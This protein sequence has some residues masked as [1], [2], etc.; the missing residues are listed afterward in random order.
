M[1]LHF[2]GR[3]AQLAAGVRFLATMMKL[4]KH[5]VFR[6]PRPFGLAGSIPAS[7]TSIFFHTFAV[8]S[9]L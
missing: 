9:V 6:S 8:L 1:D 5:T 2:Y 4:G 3:V 7:G